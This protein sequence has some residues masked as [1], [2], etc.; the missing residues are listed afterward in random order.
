MI[1]LN[2]ARFIEEAI[3][4]VFA[5][6]YERW[7]LLLVDDG[8]SDAST[9]IACDLVAHYPDRVRYLEHPGHQNC[10]MSA[11]RN[12]GISQAAGDYVAFL[13]ADDV[14][15]SHKLQEQVAILQEQPTAAMLYGQT[16]YWH[17]WTGNPEDAS[18]DYMPPSGLEANTLATPPGLL[19]RFLRGDAAVPCTCS[20]LVRRN[21]FEQF[22]GFVES[23]RGLYEDQAFYARVC[24][25]QPVLFANHCWD[26]YRQ[27]QASAC[28]TA[29]T[30]GQ[31]RAARL[32]F[33]AW[34]ETYMREQGSRDADLWRALRSAQRQ[35]RYPAL[36][37]LPK[38]K[39]RLQAVGAGR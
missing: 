29:V 27:H 10:G 14:W 11:S 18:R 20:I 33:L 39:R 31:S 5:Q 1:F 32:N 28:S 4:S 6:T 17:S 2:E 9:D 24:L 21:F 23:F 35:T 7:E 37:R 16:L 19:A 36:A 3:A 34:L 26:H 25:H 8:S 13:D 30:T 15:L 12:L 22:G 38:I